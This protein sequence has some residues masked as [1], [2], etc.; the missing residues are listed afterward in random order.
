MARL[1]ELLGLT[2]FAFSTFLIALGAWLI[3]VGR[4]AFPLW[5]G[6]RLGEAALPLFTL[7]IAANV[8]RNTPAPYAHYLVATAQ[9]RKILLAPLLEG[10]SNLVASVLLAWRYGAMGV[11]IGT[12]IGAVVGV[13]ANPLYTVPRTA[14]AGFGAGAFLRDTILTPALTCAPLLGA[15]VYALAFSRSVAL[16]GALMALGTIWPAWRILRAWRATD[17]SEPMAEAMG[18]AL[19][20]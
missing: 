4:A 9:Q 15:S 3:V 16:S 18:S 5:V 7:L 2:S 12:L 6:P 11:A 13:A 20:G 19:T 14:P 17:T 8:V 10:G 1:A